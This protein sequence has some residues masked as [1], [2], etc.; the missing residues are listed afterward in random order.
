MLGSAGRC[1]GM[2]LCGIGGIVVFGFM[3]S[4]TEP[5]IGAILGG[6]LG[7]VL[8]LLVGFFACGKYKEIIE[9][10]DDAVDTQH[11]IPE[12]MHES[13][14]GHQRFTLYV[15]V[16]ELK[17]SV[18]NEFFGFGEPDFFI[19]VR[20]GRNPPKTTCVRGGGVWNETF[21]LVVEPMDTAVSFDVVDQNTLIDTKVGSVAVPLKQVIEG[22]N[23]PPAS[24]KMRSKTRVAGDLL[25]SFRCGEDIST[26]HGVPRDMC[27]QDTTV[28]GGGGGHYG[29][30][31]SKAYFNTQIP[32]GPVISRP[33]TSSQMNSAAQSRV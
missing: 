25:V 17:N 10:A 24:F 12:S 30:F 2:V 31:G 19:R 8:G 27:V 22:I 4:L 9:A 15:T 23:G 18:N 1:L 14:F 26:T 16:H 6:I 33:P 3:G 7:M 5:G 29:T 11:F 21:K 28:A 13:V 32:S 20:C